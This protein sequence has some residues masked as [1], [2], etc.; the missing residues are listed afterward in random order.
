MR[1]RSRSQRGGRGL[2]DRRRR[3]LVWSAA[4][5]IAVLHDARAR[6][7]MSDA[8]SPGACETARSA[9]EASDASRRLGSQAEPER[10]ADAAN[11]RERVLRVAEVGRR[12]RS[13]RRS[14][15]AALGVVLVIRHYESSLPSVEKLKRATTRRR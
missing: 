11:R 14:S 10:L 5:L 7:L 6:T 8:R 1:P 9:L 13:A 12:R 4:S 3:S 15:L 2:L